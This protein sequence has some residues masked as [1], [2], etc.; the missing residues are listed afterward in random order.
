MADSSLP[1][2]VRLRTIQYNPQALPVK[3]GLPDILKELQ[4]AHALSL[5]QPADAFA[6]RCGCPVSF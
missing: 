2:D 3:R 5:T 4:S 6:Y 1:T